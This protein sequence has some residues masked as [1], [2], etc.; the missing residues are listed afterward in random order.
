MEF[1]FH[2]NLK[3]DNQRRK[4]V[5]NRLSPNPTH[6]LTVKRSIALI[7][8]GWLLRIE[9]DFDTVVVSDAQLTPDNGQDGRGGQG[10][11]ETVQGA[12]V[13]DEKSDGVEPYDLPLVHVLVLL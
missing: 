11:V 6:A 7:A 10:Q 2:A 12:Q 4:I 13:H 9:N 1:R 3:N 8:E 5:E